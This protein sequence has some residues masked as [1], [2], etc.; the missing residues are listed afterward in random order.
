[1]LSLDITR[2]KVHCI[3]RALSSFPYQFHV[4]PMS[5]YQ[6]FLQN[7]SLPDTRTDCNGAKEKREQMHFRSLSKKADIHDG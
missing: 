4:M 1:M 2:S 5:L 7:D 3:L 6:L